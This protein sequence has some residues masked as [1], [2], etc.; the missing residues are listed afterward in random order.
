MPQAPAPVQPEREPQGV[1]MADV[2]PVQRADVQPVRPAAAHP[3]AQ[4]EPRVEIDEVIQFTDDYELI[5]VKQKMLV[6][7]DGT[8]VPM[9]EDKEAPLPRVEAV[10]N[11]QD[12]ILHISEYNLHLEG[13]SRPGSSEAVPQ[14]RDGPAEASAVDAV[15]EHADI[16]VDTREVARGAPVADSAETG[17]TV[18]IDTVDPD[19]V[20]RCDKGKRR[21]T[22]HEYVEAYPDHGPKIIDVPEELPPGVASEEEYRLNVAFFIKLQQEADRAAKWVIPCVAIHSLVLTDRQSEQHKKPERRRLWNCE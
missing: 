20:P 19:Q 5:T 8:R 6:W 18:R 1:K 16:Q 11:R 4:G 22:E 21:M 9:G 15:I 17:T 12:D 10:P 14:D 3:Q 7:P 13:E 2:H